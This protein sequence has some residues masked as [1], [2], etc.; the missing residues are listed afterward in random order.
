MCGKS[1]PK[2]QLSTG[3][4]T[5]LLTV[6]CTKSRPHNTHRLT[7]NAYPKIQSA[8]GACPQNTHRL[9]SICGG[10]TVRKATSG[11]QSGI[12]RL[13]TIHYIIPI[14]GGQLCERDGYAGKIVTGINSLTTLHVFWAAAKS[15]TV[16]LNRACRVCERPQLPVTVKQNNLWT[17]V[18]HLYQLWLCPG[19]GASLHGSVDGTQE[20][21]EGG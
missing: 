8:A 5:G 11:P 1:A 15:L 13:P 17:A 3:L 16:R 10:T 12:L 4:L 18:P 7:H 14:I 2:R 21:T 19:A 9:L 6:L 20:W